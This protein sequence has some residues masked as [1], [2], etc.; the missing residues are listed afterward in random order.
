M[1]ALQN[2]FAPENVL[3]RAPA[4]IYVHSH[5]HTSP[6]SNMHFPKPPT[7]S[8]LCGLRSDVYSLVHSMLCGAFLLEPGASGIWIT[9]PTPYEGTLILEMPRFPA[10]P[11]NLPRLCLNSGDHGM[12]RLW[13]ERQ[14]MAR[15]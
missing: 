4:D 9:V 13:K 5:T 12:L 10:A 7:E 11:T 2:A 15:H 1:G 6:L 8:G 3:I 14:S